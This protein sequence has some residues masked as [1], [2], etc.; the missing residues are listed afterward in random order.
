[1]KNKFDNK[2][3]WNKIDKIIK[4]SLEDFRYLGN[5]GELDYY[6]QQTAYYK[7][8]SDAYEKVLIK[9][10]LIENENKI[11]KFVEKKK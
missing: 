3:Y 8:K 4:Q 2:E 6:K 9:A 1:M 7:A 10:G 11:I 5:T